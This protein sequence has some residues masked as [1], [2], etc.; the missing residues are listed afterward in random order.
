[1]PRKLAPVTLTGASFYG[2]TEVYLGSG[3]ASK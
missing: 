2:L 3:C 1:M